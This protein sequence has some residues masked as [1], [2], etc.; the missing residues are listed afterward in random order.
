V[1]ADVIFPE[2]VRRR[3]L[4]VNNREGKGKNSQKGE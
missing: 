4:G 1:G 3:L 2:R